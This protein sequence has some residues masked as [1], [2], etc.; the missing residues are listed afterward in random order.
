MFF[1]CMLLFM[2]AIILQLFDLCDILMIYHMIKYV[3]LNI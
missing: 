2:Y 1:M 3:M